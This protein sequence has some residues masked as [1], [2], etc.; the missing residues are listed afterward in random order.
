MLEVVKKQWAF[1]GIDLCDGDLQFKDINIIDLSNV[2]KTKDLQ[3]RKPQMK[4]K[5]CLR[6]ISY[7]KVETVSISELQVQ[8]WS[9]TDN[10]LQIFNNCS[11]FN[12]FRVYTEANM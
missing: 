2:Y 3:W 9:P 7:M 6:W 4:A 8:S 5:N 11:V 1:T 10:I 12:Y